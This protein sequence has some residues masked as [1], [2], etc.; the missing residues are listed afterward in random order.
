MLPLGYHCVD[1]ACVFRA[2]CDLPAIRRGLVPMLPTGSSAAV[3]LDRLA[4][5]V[6]AAN[7]GQ[8]FNNL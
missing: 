4:V 1:V 6:F 5:I 7:A 3:V 2:L 8:A